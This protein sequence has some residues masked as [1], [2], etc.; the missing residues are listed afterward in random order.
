MYRTRLL[1]LVQEM[2]SDSPER[3]EQAIL[4]PR[5]MSNDF[6]KMKTISELKG[7]SLL[8]RNFTR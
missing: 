5:A 4:F 6:G 8:G 1:S 3:A 7:M 2:T